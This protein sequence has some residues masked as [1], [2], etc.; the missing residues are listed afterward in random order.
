MPTPQSQGGSKPGKNATNNQPM[1]S[2]F[3]D[4]ALGSNLG[5]FRGLL[6]AAMERLAQFSREPIQRS[7]LW[8]S[9]PVDC[10][11]GSS[12]FV[13]AV[14]RLV[15]EPNETPETLLAKLKQLEQTFGRQPKRVLNEPRPL[16]LDLV[17][18]GNERRSTP[19]L[20]LPH[21]RAHLRAFV[22]APLAELDP[23]YRLAGQQKTATELLAEVTQE[24]LVRLTG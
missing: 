7:S 9:H 1:N 20:T 2:P 8:E 11:P 12:S 10:P 15:P 3:A 14:V 6:L 22:L 18:F 21:P 17:A 16:D 13:N 5:D 23:D 4:I 24:G 19:E